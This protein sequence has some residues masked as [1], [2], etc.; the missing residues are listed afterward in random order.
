MNDTVLLFLLITTPLPTLM[1]LLLPL[2]SR[3]TSIITNSIIH[4]SRSG[5]PCSSCLQGSDSAIIIIIIV[6][7]IIV[8]MEVEG[9]C[10]QQRLSEGQGG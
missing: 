4:Y 9:Y 7:I 8:A 1:L 5:R 6:V 2:Y 10:G 3:I